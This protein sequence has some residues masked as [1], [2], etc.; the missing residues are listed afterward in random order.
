MSP[1]EFLAFGWL[2]VC[3]G[4]FAL[5]SFQAHR[6]VDSFCAKYPDEARKRMPSAFAG[7]RSVDWL[8]YFL[9]RE[10]DSILR[11]DPELSRKW[12]QV[13]ALGVISFAAPPLA[14]LT[15]AVVF[16]LSSR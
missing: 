6:L 15:S 5:L 13:R 14:V 16:Y 8:S 9:S 2:F 4:L 12:K 3:A 1:Q 7:E 11:S 10:S